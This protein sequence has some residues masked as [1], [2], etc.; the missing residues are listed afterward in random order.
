MLA[1]PIGAL[2]WA[3]PQDWRP[4]LGGMARYRAFAAFWIVLTGP[5]FATVLHGSAIWIWHEPRL[6]QAALDIEWVH[7]LQHFSFLATALIFWWALVSPARAR[8]GAGIA[9]LFVTALHTSFLGILLVFA[10]RLWYAPMPAASAFWLTPLE[11]QQLAGLVMWIPGGLL[12]AAAALMVAAN[13]ISVD[14][15]DARRVSRT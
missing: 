6:F 14:G 1:R 3:F 13:W 15:R 4:R 12:Y 8:H 11:D 9:H 7:W 2:L 5:L 10:P